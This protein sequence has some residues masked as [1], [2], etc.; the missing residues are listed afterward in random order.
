MKEILKNLDARGCDTEGALSRFLGDAE[1]YLENLF[2]FTKEP[3][4]DMLLESLEK[5]DYQSAFAT[6]HTLKGAAASLGLIPLYE[7][8]CKVVE[9]L[10]GLRDLDSLH[11]DHGK[12]RTAYQDFRNIM[13]ET[14]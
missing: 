4:F 10:R 9:D 2:K 12:M 8:M 3:G 13:G 5:K 7:C 14:D 1:M 6:A 11:E